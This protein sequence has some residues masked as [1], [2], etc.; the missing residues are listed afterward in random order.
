V[1]QVVVCDSWA[2]VGSKARQAGR[3]RRDGGD[4]VDFNISVKAQAAKGDFLF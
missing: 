4:P 1:A 3:L 2:T